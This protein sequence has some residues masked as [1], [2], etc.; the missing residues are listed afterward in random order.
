MHLIVNHHE[1]DDFV[2]ATG[3]TRSVREMCEFVFRELGM[4]YEQFVVVNPRHFRP[5]ELPYLKG[6]A[7]KAMKTLG[8]K[9]EI[10]FEEM[11]REMID[12]WT[13]VLNK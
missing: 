7:S 13:A 4:H 3:Q 8:W 12:H 6:D 11:M 2:I 9:P 10:T 1:P 5:E